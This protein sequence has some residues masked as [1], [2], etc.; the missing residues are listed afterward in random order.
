MRMMLTAAVEEEKLEPLLLLL[1]IEN[2]SSSWTC[3]VVGYIL[4]LSTQPCAR[5]FMS[6]YIIQRLWHLSILQS[7]SYNFIGS[8][9][10]CQS[11][12]ILR[13][14]QQQ[15]HQPFWKN[16]F[17]METLR[18][19][20]GVFAHR[21]SFCVSL[22][23]FMGDGGPRV[24]K[25]EKHLPSFLSKYFSLRISGKIEFDSFANNCTTKRHFRWILGTFRT[26]LNLSVA[27]C[28]SCLRV[29]LW[30]YYNGHAILIRSSTNKW[31]DEHPEMQIKRLGI[32]GRD[33][34]A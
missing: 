20:G 21:S 24:H 25:R 29:V 2:I 23:R 30:V 16:T 27:L 19:E 26:P 5:E 22:L 1:K 34:N 11:W 9:E 31:Q 3:C 10:P 14:K 8:L 18:E 4:H 12:R 13:W 6:R 15:H 17:F 32:C 33:K 28:S 7:H